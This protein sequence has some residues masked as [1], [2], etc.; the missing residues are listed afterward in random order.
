MIGRGARA[1]EA[2]LLAELAALADASR[3]DPGLLGRPVRVVVPSSS[4]RE[5]LAARIVRH[6][7]RAVA[8]VKVQ[9]LHGVALEIL[10]DAAVPA[11][12]GDALLPILVRQLARREPA[13]RD[14]LEPLHDA[15][16]AV[17][18][19]VS[20]LL[21]AGFDPAAH[22]E[23]V[24]EWLR[25]APLAAEARE[26]V[27][28]L[29]RIAGAT[30]GELARLGCGR[31]GTRLAL[32]A[33]LLARDPG[34]LLPARAV[35]VHGFADATG[36]ASDLL[37][38]LVRQRG[39]RVFVDHPPDPVEPG[40]PDV[41]VAFTARLCERI[42]GIAGSEIADAAPPPVRL[43]G[44]RASG[45]QAEARAVADRVGALVAAGIR[46]E[47]IGVVARSLGAYTLPLRLHLRRLGVPFSG[48]GAGGPPSGSGRRLHALLD[49]L[50]RGDECA[51]DRWLDAWSGVRPG[52][53]F[54]L[55]LALHGVGSAR[56]RDVAALDPAE[57][58]RGR[59]WV[60]L[61][62]RRGLEAG[63]EGARARS[64][65]LDAAVLEEAVAAARALRAAL[66]RWPAAASLDVHFATLRSLVSRELHWPAGDPAAASLEAALDHLERDLPGD[67]ALARDDFVQVVQRPLRE[68]AATPLGGEGAGVQVLS[69]TE[70][71]ART[72]D[73][74]FVLGLNREVFPR[75][76]VEDP[77]LPDDL[78]RRLQDLL[79]EIPIKA[80]GF[81]EEHYL[82]A[83]LLSAS[84]QV[85]LS[86]QAVGDDGKARTPSPLVERLRIAGDAFP[87]ESAPSLHARPGDARPPRPAHEA[88]LLEGL[89]GSRKAF[90]DLLEAAL[91]ER[92]RS[93]P[94]PGEDAARLAQG[95]LAVLR[96]LERGDE[97]AGPGPY[98]GFVGPARGP[99][100]PRTRQT[101]VTLAE[102]IAGC[103][104]QTLLTR[105][106]GL[107]PPPD[108]LEALPAAT[109][110][111]VGGV[112]HEVLERIAQA[113]L[114]D[115]VYDLEALRERA[116]VA[117]AWPEPEVLERIL[118]E[119]ARDR[120]RA[121]GI[122]LPGFGPLVA[123]AARPLVEAARA[124]DWPAP[125]SGIGLL[126]VEVVGA[127]QVRDGAGRTRSL[128][129]RAD[130]VDLVDGALRLVDYKS[131]RSISEA[132][133]E[134]TLRRHLLQQVASG[135]KLQA[136]AY[137]LG[138]RG[139]GRYLFLKHAGEP[140]ARFD[141]RADDA[142]LCNA[143]ET[144]LRA[145]FEALDRGSLFPRLLDAD[146]ATPRRCE[147]CQ[148][149]M[150]CL[151]GDSS[152][153]R[154]V[155]RWLDAGG[156]GPGAEP[157]ERAFR[158]LWDVGRGTP[159]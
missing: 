93:A 51:M 117:V 152:A 63:D 61:A 91:R 136:V 108:A 146:G 25:E 44:I 33:A 38:A 116:P 45:A 125:G 46:P 71:R 101:F 82:F 115:D 29:A 84:P 73:H 64:R 3:A 133:K 75:P 112:V 41:G 66:A 76:V 86:W 55:R 1:C 144:A 59:A 15:Y 53:R 79:R 137:A 85:T 68:A 19:D 121:E 96:E 142:E 50:V 65:T 13:L 119:C 147:W 35:L 21:D 135:E 120:V 67:H 40:Q 126:G 122:G 48:P 18:A 17:V 139:E 74:L 154:R 26:R 47:T 5:H 83:Q 36:V 52:R 103:P 31:R 153:R 57:V 114:G 105:L 131:G 49:V 145:V 20:D 98:L 155:A 90:A 16:G 42:G 107:E 4:L 27:R 132:V 150:A 106:L 7:G 32:A 127:A 81:D 8:G 6:A 14:V 140:C 97:H 39:A 148:V 95:R 72:F 9:T 104:W 56:L 54:D 23:A 89:H 156:G 134:D 34:S 94:A 60:P 22:G 70:A 28:A 138:S 113:A 157:A 118:Q 87:I 80:R 109:P 143:F 77:L 2:L 151:Q 69:V 78:R 58:L 92:Q 12:R 62:A 111:L 130:R 123:D 102:G 141:A 159:S 128:A 149:R 129:F 110:L 24:E 100:D 43:A 158:V 10:S 11:P 88:A 37:E 124:L 99:T 30:A